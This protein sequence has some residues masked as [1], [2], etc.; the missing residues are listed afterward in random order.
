MDFTK[1]INFVESHVN[2]LARSYYEQLMKSEY[3][4]TYQKLDEVKVIEREE[5]VF[6]NFINWLKNGASNDEAEKYFEKVGADRFNEGFPLTEINY[7]L[8]ITKKV[9]WSTIAWKKELFEDSEFHQLIE[10]MTI[11]NNYFDL[12]SF[13][14]IRGY[15]NMLFTKLDISDKLTRE[16]IHTI[17]VRG[18][19]DDDELDK[20]DFV[21]RHV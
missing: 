12:G 15:I 11:L 20:S 13:Y 21:W 1:M 5:L 3:M 9:F 19:F 8:Y 18:A 10:Y 4:T 17:L 2:I 6:K 16:E 14:L 7:A